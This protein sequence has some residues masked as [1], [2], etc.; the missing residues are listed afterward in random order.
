LA[1]PADIEARLR[2]REARVERW[3]RA[4]W[5]GPTDL[6]YR[7]LCL[8]WFVAS[9][10]R[11]TLMEAGQPSWWIATGVLVLGSVQLV[12]RGGRIGWLLSLVGLLVPLWWLGDW[13]T[14][15]VILALI[16]AV[17]VAT[18][19][20]PDRDEPASTP[21]GSTDGETQDARRAEGA[22][23]M[24]LRAVGVAAHAL[25]ASTYFVAVFHK[26]NAGFI[27]PVASCANHGWRQLGAALVFDLP[28]PDPLAAAMPWLVLATE[29]T[30]GVLVARRSRWAIPVGVALH[31]PFT[32]ALAPAFAFVMAVGYVAATPGEV[33]DRA[34]RGLRE[35]APRRAAEAA[36]I[37]AATVALTP[38]F[39]VVMGIKVA[40]LVQL[41]VVVH[42]GLWRDVTPSPAPKRARAWALAV[43]A[44]FGLNAA[45]PYLGTQMQHTGAMLSNLRIDTACS[46][47]LVVPA[48]LRLVDP[49]VRIDAASLGNAEH[50]TLGAYPDDELALRSI[51]WSTTALRSMRRNWCTERT[52]PIRLEGTF[53]GEPLVI[54]D[55]CD[56]ATPLPRGPGAFGGPGVFDG[57]LRLQKNLPR[58][59]AMTCVH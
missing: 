54:E 8:A 1:T 12:W 59:C 44:G 16:A 25:V 4:W 7:A 58:S 47:H 17:G 48:T 19:R 21:S 30:V 22:T 27:D 23:A 15:S 41:A 11:C 57:Y 32:L 31:V 34:W 36:A 33:L 13:L 56:P 24:P 10:A 52:R 35:R 46:N 40:L 9:L 51:L 6:P 50:G 14:Q 5:D 3:R 42:P 18:T 45:T 43:V 29:L 20:A 38:G 37:A 28:L 2:A 49:Y 55:L 53:L 26:L 39:D